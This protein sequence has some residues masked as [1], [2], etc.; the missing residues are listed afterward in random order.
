MSYCACPSV[1]CATGRCEACPCHAQPVDKDSCDCAHGYICAYHHQ[2][3]RRFRGVSREPES[4][5]AGLKQP[6]PE[7]GP[8]RCELPSEAYAGWSK[9]A[10][11][12]HEPG[13]GLAECYAAAADRSRPFYGL[14]PS[15]RFALTRP[16]TPE[17]FC[18]ACG[19]V[20]WR[21]STCRSCTALARIQHETHRAPLET[22]GQP[23]PA[24][25]GG[26]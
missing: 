14:D 9:D 3:E 25:K 4:T 15:E 17:R 13:R 1:P 22:T 19:C 6:T 11:A 8:G 5:L 2:V 12:G 10:I 18:S 24:P 21:P 7:P 26:R 16:P 20:T 23:K